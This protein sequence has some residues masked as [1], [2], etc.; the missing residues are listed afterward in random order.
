MLKFSNCRRLEIWKSKTGEVKNKQMNKSINSRRGGGGP[1]PGDV[2]SWKYAFLA[3]LFLLVCFLAR[4]NFQLVKRLGHADGGVPG[5]EPAS[6]AA[7]SADDERRV[8]RL[9]RDVSEMKENLAGMRGALGEIERK[10][11]ELSR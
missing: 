11:A 3:S 6:A 5:A 9:R 1:S 7:G 4:L 8:S 10:H 2:A